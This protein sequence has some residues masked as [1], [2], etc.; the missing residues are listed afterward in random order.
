MDGFRQMEF[1]LPESDVGFG[2]L[3]LMLVKKKT[4]KYCDLL[5]YCHTNIYMGQ[6]RQEVKRPKKLGFFSRLQLGLQT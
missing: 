2:F 1:A 4:G 6:T 3:Y 5:I